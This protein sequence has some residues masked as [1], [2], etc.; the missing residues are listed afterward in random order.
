YRKFVEVVQLDN[1]DTIWP[2]VAR[3]IARLNSTPSQPVKTVILI[4]KYSLIISSVD[5]SY[6]PGPWEQHILYGYGVKPEDLQ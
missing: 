6:H 2:D 3:R 4:Q 1:F 5:G